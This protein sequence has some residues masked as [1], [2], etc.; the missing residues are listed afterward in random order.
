MVLA[1]GLGER[2]L[3]LTRTVPKPAI[4]VL[5]RPLLAQVIARL[6][7]AGVR[8][9]AINLHHLPD[10]VRAVA[11]A[12]IPAGFDG[13]AFFEEA[14]TILG[15]GGG[16]KNAERALRG[17]G[18]ILVRNSDFLT[19]V[20]IA[21]ALEA[22]RRSG[23]PATL[24]L[25]PERPGYTPLDVDAVGRVVSIG[26]NPPPPA[27]SSVFRGTFTGLHFIEEEVLDRLPAG[28]PSDIVREVYRPLV[29]EHRLGAWI[30]H[31]HWLE[32]G[33]PREYLDGS[34][35]LLDL[36]LSQLRRFAEPD[37]I[38]EFP[39]ARVAMGAGADADDPEASLRGR[40]ALGLAAHV[41]AGA[42]ILDSVVL[43]E[44][45]IGPGAKLARVVVGPGAEIPA[46]FAI[47]EAMICADPGVGFA[48]PGGVERISGLL[49]RRFA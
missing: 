28:R 40:V 1:A 24:V 4:P 31:G 36:P 16:L 3:P 26:G 35:H 7:A 32:F 46:G 34:M 44:A 37:P 39:R 29:A 22:H 10:Q 42:R 9:L 20:P 49:V 18:T 5:G 12:A 14:G 38:R 17:A 23:L 11:E 2:M 45:W 48:L 47:E 6:A 25:V 30:H 41:G 15:T 8:S 13:L 27:G 33:T 43:P 21:D 19:D